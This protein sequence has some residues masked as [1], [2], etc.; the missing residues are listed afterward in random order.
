MEKVIYCVLSCITSLTTVPHDVLFQSTRGQAILI[1]NANL[2][3]L[4]AQN[5]EIPL[6]YFSIETYQ[7]RVRGLNQPEI[8]AVLEKRATEWSPQMLD[9]ALNWIYEQERKMLS[10]TSQY[11]ADNTQKE[12][13]KLHDHLRDTVALLSH[14]VGE[15][16][17]ED[18]SFAEL[19]EASLEKETRLKAELIAVER[20]QPA[21]ALELPEHDKTIQWLNRQLAEQGKPEYAQAPLYTELWRGLYIEPADD[22]LRAQL[23][24]EYQPFVPWKDGLVAR[25]R[26]RK[27][28]ELTQAGRRSELLYFNS[29][30]F[31]EDLQELTSAQLNHVFTV[32][33]KSSS[34]LNERLH[35][36]NGLRLECLL[37][38]QTIYDRSLAEKPALQQAIVSVI[39]METARL[40]SRLAADKTWLDEKINNQ[41]TAKPALMHE[42]QTIV[43][44][45]ELFIGLAQQNKR[46][47]LVKSLSSILATKRSQLSRLATLP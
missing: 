19:L 38:W 16:R 12:T 35:Y 26:V 14:L 8:E 43:D 24:L 41:G 15:G 4:R 27:I 13:A 39:E 17:Y 6:V 36:L 21:F 31:I 42:E 44:D 1:S 29:G 40:T 5:P 32:R 45:V 3:S 30:E 2:L 22:N 47:D 9:H 34:Q 10:L 20:I 18:A 23:K 11:I 37:L 7:N 46:L 25:W 33:E 28:P